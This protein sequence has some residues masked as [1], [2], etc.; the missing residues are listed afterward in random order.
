LLV[1]ARTSFGAALITGFG[2]RFLGGSGLGLGTLIPI[3]FSASRCLLD[4]DFDA[5]AFERVMNERVLLLTGLGTDLLATFAFSII[6]LNVEVLRT[7]EVFAFAFFFI[8]LSVF[9]K[10]NPNSP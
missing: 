2:L 6:F 10:E 9:L 8:R 5:L 4:N 1:I 3:L 7:D